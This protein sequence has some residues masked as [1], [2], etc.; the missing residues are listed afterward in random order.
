MMIS[1]VVAVFFLLVAILITALE[2]HLTARS[3]GGSLLERIRNAPP[4]NDVVHTLPALAVPQAIE[5][6]A[7]S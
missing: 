5:E 6:P 4:N 2:P 7:I 1:I 3:T